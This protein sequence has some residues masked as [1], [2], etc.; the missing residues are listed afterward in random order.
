MSA[1][2]DDPF[3]LA[4]FVEAQAGVYAQV[5]AELRAGE[6]RSHWMWFIFPQIAGLGHSPM[7]R[8]YA[9][10]SIHEARAY[11]AHPILGPRLRECTQLMLAAQ[12]RTSRQLLG[13][14]D[15]QKFRSSITLFARATPED[16]LFQDA[17]DKYFDGEADEAA[18]LKLEARN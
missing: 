15:S 3:D 7:A 12:G 9:I 18:L 6:K 10:S 1:E 2:A 4:R 5:C 8:R 14:I 17:L 11:L 13:D 16:R